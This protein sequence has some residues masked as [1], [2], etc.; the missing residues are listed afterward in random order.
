MFGVCE[1]YLRLSVMNRLPNLKKKCVHL[2]PEDRIM[3]LG[4]VVMVKVI[5]KI[6]ENGKIIL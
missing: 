1:R 4:S 6:L 3:L 5:S 2:L